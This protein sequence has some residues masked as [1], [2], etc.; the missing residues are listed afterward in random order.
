MI[1]FTFG[2]TRSAVVILFI[3]IPVPFFSYVEQLVA[4][5]EAAVEEVVRRGVSFSTSNFH[6][7]Q[8]LQ[9][10]DNSMGI[11]FSRWLIQTKLLLVV[12]HMGLS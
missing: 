11:V 12:T 10:A 7:K 9:I 8:F 6:K 2:W 4:S 3:N 5:A 1:Y